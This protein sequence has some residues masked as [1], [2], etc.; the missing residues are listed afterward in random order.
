MLTQVARWLFEPSGLTPHGFC[1]LWEPYLIYTHV[2]ANTIT[3]LSYFAIPVILTG[4]VR[5]RVIDVF[6]PAFTL[7]GAFIL[8]CGLGH[9]VDLVTLWFPIYRLQAAIQAAT[10]SVSLMTAVALWRLL[11]EVLALPSPGDFRKMQTALLEREGREKEM[12]A[13]NKELE[14]L[15]RHLTRAGQEAEKASRAKS[16]FLAG[17]SH[18]LRTPLNGIIG[19]AHLLRTE[20]GLT[21]GQAV[22]VESMLGAGNH[23]LEMITCVLDMSQIEASHIELHPVPVDLSAIAA[24]CL[25][26]VRPGADAKRLTLCVSVAPGAQLALVADPT[27]LRQILLNLLSNAVK[28]TADGAIEVRL[29]PMLNRTSLR[30]DVT[31]TGPGIAGNQ[32]GR[33]FQDFERLNRDE[34]EQ[35]EGAGLGLAISSRLAVLM[36]GTLGHEDN[37]GGGSIFWLELPVSSAGAQPPAATET[38]ADDTGPIRALHVLIV[39]D[40]AMNRDIAGSL[41]R[42][43]GHVVTYASSGAEAVNAAT[44]TDFDAVLMDVRMPGMDGLEATR[45]IRALGDPRGRVPI[46]ALTAQAFA[47]Q[48]DECRKVGMNGHIPKPFDPKALLSTISRVANGNTADEDIH[49]SARLRVAALAQTNGEPDPILSQTVFAQTCSIIAPGA[50]AAYL[51]S[52]KERSE[53]ILCKLQGVDLQLG[54]NTQLAEVVHSLCGSAG[55]FGFLRLAVAGLRF[56]QALRTNA[57]DRGAAA[58][59][60]ESALELTLKELH[61]RVPPRVAA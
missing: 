32:R 38:L 36:G 61:P 28:F 35:V 17:M 30:I 47:E 11:P 13:A 49:I 43:A 6:R 24:A 5:R 54:P 56:E 18:E 19:Y 40:A 15:A 4:L 7:F 51:L 37:P 41:L 22:R 58:D 33:L 2:I 3:G 16:L 8:L 21:A 23:L 52:I 45:R 14:R 60:F 31:D 25:D 46:V 34:A 42:A 44:H 12:A 27:R 39:D 10:A 50:Q 9:W 1:L 55:M 59:A 29:R 26:L 57:P 20:G 48:V 53:A